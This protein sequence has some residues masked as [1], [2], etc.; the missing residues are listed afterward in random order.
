MT[1]FAFAFRSNW[2]TV[3]AVV[4][5]VSGALILEYFGFDRSFE[6]A[7]PILIV[8]ALFTALLNRP[9]A[10]ELQNVAPKVDEIKSRVEKLR[11]KSVLESDD[12]ASRKVEAARIEETIAKSSSTKDP[13]IKLRLKSL[14][15]RLV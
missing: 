3:V 11:A 2:H 10:A 12:A 8:L 6:R 13:A 5:I 15:E 4:A 7:G 1:P 9:L 14:L